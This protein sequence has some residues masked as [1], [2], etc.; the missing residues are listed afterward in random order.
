MII[1][2]Y[3]KDNLF[4]V[5]DSTNTDDSFYQKNV[6]KRFQ[7]ILPF[8]LNGACLHK[9]AHLPNFYSAPLLQPVSIVENKIIFS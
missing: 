2:L 3:Q 9:N 6:K 1:F 5:N 7:F 8:S 4:F